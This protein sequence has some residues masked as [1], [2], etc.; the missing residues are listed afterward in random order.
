MC[1]IRKGKSLLSKNKSL[2]PKVNFKARIE[3]HSR[4]LSERK[5]Y[6]LHNYVNP[7]KLTGYKV[8]S[9]LVFFI[10]PIYPTFAFFVTNVSETDFSREFID[11]SSILSSYF[12]TGNTVSDGEI[13][14][15]SK[16]SFLYINA[17]IDSQRDVSG[18]SEIVDYEVKPGESF[19][20]IA[21][22][23][24]I[25]KDSI[26]WANDFEKSKVLHPGDIIKIPPVSGIVHTVKSGETLS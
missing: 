25:S 7:K 21:Q 23:F 3:R 9:V 17:P 4:I 26:Y 1:I 16:D 15:Q 11:E 19:A 24:N 8:L 22:K 6:N 5:T 10:V 20:F 13:F 14:I 12:G 2:G 18:T